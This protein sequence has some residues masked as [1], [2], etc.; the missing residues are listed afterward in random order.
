MHSSS[1]TQNRLRLCWQILAVAIC[2]ATLPLPAPTYSTPRALNVGD[3]YEL[4]RDNWTDSPG[5]QA[6]QGDVIPK[7]DAHDGLNGDNQYYRRHN[8]ARAWPAD[9]GYWFT[10]AD[11]QPGEPDP[12]GEQWVDYAPPFEILG[13]G[14]YTIFGSYRWG[15]TRASYPAVYRVYHALGTNDVLRDQ[16]IGTV[17]QTIE[18]FLI[19]TYEMRPSSFVRVE[20]TGAESIT[21]AHMRFHYVSPVPQLQI[22]L[23]NGLCYLAWP[24]NAQA[25]RLEWT[26]DTSA[27][28]N[29]QPV[30]E[31]PVT[32]SNLLVVSVPASNHAQMFRL[33]QP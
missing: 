14:R 6:Y 24:T 20:D 11:Q 29:W 10:A 18:Y 5:G 12:A 7:T 17:G 13:P 25:Y 23:T 4:R 30:V 9:V 19:G 3:V 1:Q 21:F 15:A 27:M 33:V 32:F 8:V 2:M 26:P 31:V 22:A 28:T 16:R